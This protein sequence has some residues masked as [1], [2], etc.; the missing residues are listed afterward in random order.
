[1]TN[2]TFIGIRCRYRLFQKLDF[3]TD[4]DTDTEKLRKKTRF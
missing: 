3:D 2:R 1:M 4:N